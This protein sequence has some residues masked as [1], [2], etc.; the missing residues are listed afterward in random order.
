MAAEEGS[1]DALILLSALH[2]QNFLVVGNKEEAKRLL[3]RAAELED[4][5]AQ[6]LL[7]VALLSGELPGEGKETTNKAIDLLELSASAGDQFAQWNLAIELIEGTEVVENKLRA[8]ELLETS[9]EGL[10]PQDK[11]WSTDGFKERFASLAS[12]LE[13]FSEKGQKEAR[14]WLGLCLENAIGGVSKDRDKSMLLYL[15]SAEQGYELARQR[16]EQAP[17]NLQMLARKK[18]LNELL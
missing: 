8:K 14:Y 12:L 17:T 2:N 15:K 9:A 5:R 13:D 11:V 18:F 16:F 10:F 6:A 3:T 1:C 4:R 7:G